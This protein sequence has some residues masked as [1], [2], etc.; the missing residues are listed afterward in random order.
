MF[1]NTLNTCIYLNYPKQSR[2]NIAN[3]QIYINV[4]AGGRW[5]SRVI[6]ITHGGGETTLTCLWLTAPDWTGCTPDSKAHGANM[7]P[8]GADRTQ[9]GLMLATWTLLS[10]TFQWDVSISH[11]AHSHHPLQISNARNLCLDFFERSRI[12]QELGTTA[13]ESPVISKID[14]NILILNPTLSCSTYGTPFTNRD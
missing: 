11:S 4:V 13:A 6:C 9:M 14:I 2:Y 10:R 7:G 1:Y 8:P 5:H 3:W 12:F